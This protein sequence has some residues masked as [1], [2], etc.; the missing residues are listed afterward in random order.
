MNKQISVRSMVL[1][2]LL[3]GLILFSI[4]ATTNKRETWEY[5]VLSGYTQNLNSPNNGNFL[6]SL[7]E[8]AGNEGWEAV[9][10]TQDGSSPPFFRVLLKRAK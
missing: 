1:G 5:H 6:P 4:G 7:L 8:T 9:S 3:G 10:W 2:L